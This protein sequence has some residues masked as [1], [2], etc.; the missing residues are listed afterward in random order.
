MKYIQIILLFASF[1]Y[2][3]EGNQIISNSASKQEVF[4]ATPDQL[5]YVGIGNEGNRDIN[6]FDNYDDSEL[7][8]NID[9]NRKNIQEILRLLK[10]KSNPIAT[11]LL[12][13]ANG[14]EYFIDENGNKV[15][16]DDTGK[17]F[18]DKNGNSYKV[19]V[20][21]NGNKW[22]VGADGIPRKVLK[23]ENG[24]EYF[25]DE[26]GNRVY[27]DEGT[28]EDLKEAGET[29][30]D[31]NGNSY[32]V[33][34][35]K[36]G[37]KWVVGADGIPRKVLKDANGREY[38]IDENGNR[39]YLD[40]GVISSSSVPTGK[41]FRTKDGKLYSIEIDK[42]GNKWVVGADGVKRRVLK[43]AN[44]REYFIDENGNRVYLDEGVLSRKK[45]NPDG[46]TTI[47]VFEGGKWKKPNEVSDEKKKLIDN[48]KEKPSGDVIIDGKDGYY[49]EEGNFHKYTEE[50]AKKFGDNAGTKDDDISNDKIKP[51]SKLTPPENARIKD[52]EM[53]DALNMMSMLQKN[54]EQNKQSKLF[55][56]Q[57]IVAA[58]V[59]PVYNQAK[60]DNDIYVASLGEEAV[61]VSK[62]KVI[63]EC[64]LDVKKEIISQTEHMEVFCES[65]KMGTFVM[66]AK[67]KSELKVKI[68]TLT[69]V[70]KDITF[71]IK[72]YEN[73]EDYVIQES[74][75]LNAHTKNSNIAT[76]VNMRRFEN[77]LSKSGRES[78]DLAKTGIDKYNEALT[79]TLEDSSTTTNAATGETT[80]ASI[81]TAPKLMDYLTPS[82]IQIAMNFA[83]NGV[84]AFFEDSPIV[85]EIEAGTKLKV[86]LT[87]TKGD[88]N[89]K[90]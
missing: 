51:V 29:F 23:D 37:N 31:K 16:V 69:A 19:V 45:V 60:I 80:T 54:N 26:N 41:V 15:F 89:E 76:R 20:D 22:V 87:L 70:A 77:W 83:G 38:F 39:V 25:I 58:D 82:G 90:K 84:T 21:K 50:D 62:T 67:L 59:Y 72:G 79:T 27:L 24:R 78:Y 73:N 49:D 8:K 5:D 32:K 57:P 7:K 86:Y 28:F 71:N 43:D 75:I 4:E 66:L 64:D 36:N 63:A 81:T 2:S 46:S 48:E 56:S 47:E 61:E 85:Y 13:D 65:Q 10:N 11:K 68:P 40:E 1:L 6:P 53:Q 14:R 12:K 44:G 52:I 88:I 35:D 55:S 74:L 18:T 33:V 30:T 9:K 17:I 42:N 34:V 3:Q